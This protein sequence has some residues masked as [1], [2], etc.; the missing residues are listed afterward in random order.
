VVRGPVALPIE[1]EWQALASTD[2][3]VTPLYLLPSGEINELQPGRRVSAKL[4]ERRIHQG[5]KPVTWLHHAFQTYAEDHNNIGPAF[6][7]DLDENKYRSDLLM[8]QRSSR[9]PICKCPAVS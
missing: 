6:S 5:Q 4:R 2:K 1:G 3:A 9:G 7:D 8:A